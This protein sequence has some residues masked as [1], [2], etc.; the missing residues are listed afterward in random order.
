MLTG[1]LVTYLVLAQLA[2]LVLKIKSSS[3]NAYWI[4]C[5]IYTLGS[6]G[7]ARTDNL[8]VN[9]APLYH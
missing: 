6:R 9:S 4:L 3:L 7:R 2:G 5:K 8:C 1:L